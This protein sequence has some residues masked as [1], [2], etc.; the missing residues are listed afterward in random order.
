MSFAK[1]FSAVMQR[2]ST[3]LSTE[4]NLDSDKVSASVSAF[5]ANELRLGKSSRRGTPAPRGEN[6]RGRMSGY[7]LFTEHFRPSVLAEN[8]N[9]K[10][11]GVSK[12][13]GKRWQALSDAEKQTWKDKA[14]ALNTSNGI[15]SKTPSAKTQV[16]ASTPVT[17]VTPVTP[18]AVAP[19]ASA[20]APQK[21]KTTKR[22]TDD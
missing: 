9:E 4:F 12:L 11:T 10:M 5:V 7:L 13:L 19:A 16:Q 15:V 21:K 14:A 17:Q 8:P 6:G 22:Q 2:L 1:S 18:V 20:K 3:Q